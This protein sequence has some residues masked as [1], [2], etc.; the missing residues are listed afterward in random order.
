[1]ICIKRTINSEQLYF[2]YEVNGSFTACNATLGKKT[3]SFYAPIYLLKTASMRIMKTI[4]HLSSGI[5]ESHKRSL[6]K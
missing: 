6:M 3:P 2:D 5:L 4:C 1:M